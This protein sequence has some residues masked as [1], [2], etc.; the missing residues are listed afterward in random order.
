M[1]LRPARKACSF[2]GLSSWPFTIDLSTRR[3]NVLQRSG[4]N[5][6]G[7]PSAPRMYVPDARNV[8]PGRPGAEKS[9]DVFSSTWQQKLR[10]GTPIRTYR[11][12]DKDIAK[13]SRGS[14][15]A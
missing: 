13:A 5:G 10:R 4:S 12:T 15:S 6:Q 3:E 11:P 14:L 1:E 7:C 2:G 8:E 9:D